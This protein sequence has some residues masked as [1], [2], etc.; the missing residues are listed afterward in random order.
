MNDNFLDLLQII[1]EVRERVSNLVAERDA[2]IETLRQLGI[3]WDY[4]PKE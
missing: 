3:E 4:K 1:N 2:L